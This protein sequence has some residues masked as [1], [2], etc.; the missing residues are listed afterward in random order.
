MSRIPESESDSEDEENDYRHVVNIQEDKN[1][2]ENEAVDEQGEILNIF[3]DQINNI[4]NFN[5]E[6]NLP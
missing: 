3:Q 2:A 4:D 5:E 6:E 1:L